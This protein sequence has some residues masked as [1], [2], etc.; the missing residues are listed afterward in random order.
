MASFRLLTLLWPNSNLPVQWTSRGCHAGKTRGGSWGRLQLQVLQYC[1][2]QKTLEK[3]TDQYKE[4][5]GGTEGERTRRARD[6]PNPLKPTRGVSFAS[7]TQNR[8]Q[9]CAYRVRQLVYNVTSCVCVQKLRQQHT[10][11]LS[12]HTKATKLTIVIPEHGVP[13]NRVVVVG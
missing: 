1:F 5:A 12:L 2:V 13:D 10:G 9:T 11:R 7:L 8:L 3:D 4:R 6:K